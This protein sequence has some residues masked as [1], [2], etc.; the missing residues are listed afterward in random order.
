MPN[1]PSYRLYKSLK[2]LLKCYVS[3]A[4]L[5]VLVIDL[6]GSVSLYF[7]KLEWSECAEHMMPGRKKK[8]I[9]FGLFV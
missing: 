8:L 5:L 3:T 7:K 4:V 9:S 2:G 6:M 1:K